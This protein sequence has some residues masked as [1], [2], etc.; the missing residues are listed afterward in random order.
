[1]IEDGIYIR[2]SAG[3]T[4]F[5]YSVLASGRLIDTGIVETEDTPEYYG[6]SQA[7]D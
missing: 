4:A 3:D 6:G 1:M 7:M 2:I 5:T